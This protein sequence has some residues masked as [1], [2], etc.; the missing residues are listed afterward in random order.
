MLS[1]QVVLISW[2]MF[3]PPESAEKSNSMA[4]G[5][6]VDVEAHHGSQKHV[7]L[8][9][10]DGNTTELKTIPRNGSEECVIGKD[11]QSLDRRRLMSR[12]CM[13]WRMM[14]GIHVKG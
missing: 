14:A 13:H 2:N 10:S 9:L 5:L 7:H 8:N 4:R 3:F 6:E 12:L 1:L 11:E